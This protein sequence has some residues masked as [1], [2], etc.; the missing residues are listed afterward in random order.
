M[1]K[2]DVRVELRAATMSVSKVVAEVRGRRQ[3][4]EAF[5]MPNPSIT[6]PDCQTARLV[7]EP[8]SLAPRSV[9]EASRKLSSHKGKQSIPFGL[10][11]YRKISYYK[12]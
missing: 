12:A 10:H 2:S 11:H 7:G 6:A 3:A 5:I 8:G 1:S 4:A 9:L